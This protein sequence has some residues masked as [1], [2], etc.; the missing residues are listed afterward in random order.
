MIER[1]L[2]R[3]KIEAMNFLQT[4]PELEHPMAEIL[5]DPL[6]DTGSPE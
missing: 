6:M 5:E 2:F 4:K 3:S 1:K